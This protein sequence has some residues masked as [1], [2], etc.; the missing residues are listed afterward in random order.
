MQRQQWRKKWENVETNSYGSWRKSETRKKWSMKQG[1]RDEKF[2]SRHWWNFVILRSRS[3]SLNFKSTEH[4]L[5]CCTRIFLLHSLSGYFAHFS[6]VSHTRIAQAQVMSKR[7]L[8]H[9]Y[10]TSPSCLLY[11][12]FH[13]SSLFLYIHFNITFQ[14]TILPYFPV[15]KAQDMRHSALASRSLTTWPNQMQTQVMNPRSSTISL[16]W[17]MTRYSL[18][19]QTNIASLTSR[20]PHAR[21]LNSSVFPQCFK[22]LFCKF[23]MMIFV[24]QWKQRQHTSGN[25]CK[26]ERK[27]REDSVINDVKSM[28]KKNRRNRI[29]NHLQTLR[30]QHSDGRDLREHLERR[31]QQA[32]LDENS[33]QRKL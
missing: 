32:I 31:A 19:I 8:L 17:T 11:L 4:T 10:H 23:L 12:M 24:F 15:L 9:M 6:C 16:L 26:T 1:T 25:R 7:C 28:S 22:S 18:T 14:S 21:I 30:E 13:P 29:R 20:K 2:I 27:E 3:W 5:T 33:V